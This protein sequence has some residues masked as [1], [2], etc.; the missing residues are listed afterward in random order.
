MG[1]QMHIVEAQTIKE[2]E[3]KAREWTRQARE[4]GLEDIR[5]G[6]DRSRVEK[7]EEGYRIE[8]WAHT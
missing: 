1:G 5:L 4:G 8:L 7:T 3:R 6:W 2:L